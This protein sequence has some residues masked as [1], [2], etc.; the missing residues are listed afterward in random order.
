MTRWPVQRIRIGALTATVLPL[1]EISDTLRDWFAP[2]ARAVPEG[3]S[4]LPVNALHV[5]GPGVSVLIDACDPARYPG[6][7]PAGAVGACLG[8]AGVAPEGITH[9]IVTHGHHDHFCGLITAG[10]G[11]AFPRA[12]HILSPLEWADGSLTTQAQMADGKAADP[13]ALERLFRLGLLDLGET[14]P[15]LAPE[16][17]L[18]ETPGETRGHRVVR[19][20][21]GGEVIYFLADLFH[22]RAE[23][24]DPNLCPIWA[25]ALALR[26]SRSRIITAIRRDSA[27]FLCSHLPD[28]FPASAFAKASR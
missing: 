9:V 11:P 26:A 10:G 7:G 2:D 18:I 27:R 21:S 1:G 4:H 20:A 15:P 16:L 28:V 23:I 3:V 8:R 13:S 24:E 12:R 6:A 17:T 25:D 19:I 14:T 5:G 22:V